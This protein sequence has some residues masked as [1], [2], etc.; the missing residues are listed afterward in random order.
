MRLAGII[1]YN[2]HSSQ[3]QSERAIEGQEVPGQPLT[4]AEEVGLGGE[5]VPQLLCM[6]P[7]LT[8]GDPCPGHFGASVSLP[9]NGSNDRPLTTTA[10]N[11]MCLS[12]VS[13]RS[14]TNVTYA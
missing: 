1:N 4:G 11:K 12:N 10:C 8:A 2:R 6:S 13:L 5:K 3:T 14:C 7:G 9:L